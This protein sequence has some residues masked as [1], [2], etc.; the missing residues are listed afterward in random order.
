M[1]R[2]SA[3]SARHD[4]EK[5][6]AVRLHVPRLAELASHPNS[7]PW[8]VQPDGNPVRLAPHHTY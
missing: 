3:R 2:F 5:K 6:I 4:G 7:R 1:R 8:N